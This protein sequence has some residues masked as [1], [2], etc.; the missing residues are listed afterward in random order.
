MD[1]LDAE[2]GQPSAILVVLLVTAILTVPGVIVR[3]LGGGNREF[4][5]AVAASVAVVCL[6]CAYLSS[7]KRWIH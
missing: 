7:S 6:L 2:Y 1:G 4:L 3:F 5:V